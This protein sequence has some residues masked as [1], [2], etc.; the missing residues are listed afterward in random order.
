MGP[1]LEAHTWLSQ[2]VGLR[3]CVY[4]YICFLTCMYHDSSALVQRCAP[5]ATKNKTTISTRTGLGHTTWPYTTHILCT[6]CMHAPLYSHWPGSSKH[7]AGRLQAGGGGGGGGGGRSTN[8]VC[9]MCGFGRGSVCEW[10]CCRVVCVC[11]YARMSA[12]V[13]VYVRIWSSIHALCMPTHVPA[14]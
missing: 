9:M 2:I 10:H 11:G 3:L 7:T 14:H 6:G 5:A 8:M 13:S 12:C 1:G 4:M